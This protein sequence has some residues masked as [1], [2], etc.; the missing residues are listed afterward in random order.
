MFAP[1][2]TYSNGPR[3]M[4]S[5][6]RAERVG[7]SRRR[8][9]TA[10]L[11]RGEAHSPPVGRR[12]TSDAC[13]V[14]KVAATCGRCQ[15]G[16]YARAPPRRATR[17][18]RPAAAGPAADRRGPPCRIAGAG[19]DN[20]DAPIGR[21]LAPHDP[22]AIRSHPAPN[23]AQQSAAC[24]S[25]GVDLRD[26]RRRDPGCRPC[27]RARLL[28]KAGRSLRATDAAPRD[29]GRAA[30][31]VG[32]VAVA[33]RSPPANDG[34]AIACRIIAA[35]AETSV[36]VLRVA[37]RATAAST[38]NASSKTLLTRWASARVA[39]ERIRNVRAQAILA[40]SAVCV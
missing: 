40:R 17:A 16:A 20:R 19:A 25:S 37:R 7:A 13:S 11:H 12:T 4:I 33:D 3:S 14:V 22:I 23:A 15:T 24:M 34:R 31:A 35:L 39:P 28:H 1:S 10:V 6:H 36:A 8:G 2:I 29:R 26:R 30:S 21:R 9:K 5:R 27:R 38:S 32:A 18:E